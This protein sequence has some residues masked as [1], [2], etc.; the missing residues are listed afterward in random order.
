MF[1]FSPGNTFEFT[2]ESPKYCPDEFDNLGGTACLATVQKESSWG[3]GYETCKRVESSLVG[4]DETSTSSWVVPLLS[5]YMKTK[6]LKEVWTGMCKQ[7]Y[8]NRL[9]KK[10]FLICF[11]KRP[12]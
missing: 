9:F 1:L 3:V 6:N 7:G 5:L 8:N 10:T 4:L 2:Q 12:S 11:L